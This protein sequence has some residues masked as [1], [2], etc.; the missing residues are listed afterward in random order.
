VKRGAEAFGAPGE[1][2][3]V[4][5]AFG[6]ANEV[7]TD[8]SARSSANSP[9]GL[10]FS[11]VFDGERLK[12]P[13]MQVALSHVGTHIADLRS[14][15]PGIRDLALYGAE[16]RAWQ[17]SVLNAIGVKAKALTLPGGYIIYDQSW[18]D[19]DVVRNAN[20]GIRGFL[21]NWVGITNPPKP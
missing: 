10:V 8:D 12:G 14:V 16:F 9:D 6:G 15:T 4:I 21:T 7:P 5:V 13:I 2:N 20:I 3:G 11:A 17:T 19:S 1:D 18:P